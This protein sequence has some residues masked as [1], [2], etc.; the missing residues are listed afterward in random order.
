[1]KR[2][3]LLASVCGLLVAAAASSADAQ[4]AASGAAAEQQQSTTVGEVIVTAQRRAERLQDVPITIT[5]VSAQQLKDAN[6]QNLAQVQKL[7]PALRFDYQGPFYQPSIRG[8]GS[9]IVTSGAGSNVGIYVDGFFVPNPQAA[10]LQLLNVE[11]VQVLKGPQ[12]TLFGRNTTGGAIL[13]TTTRPSVKTSGMVD[14][15]YGNYNAQRYQGY[16][17]TGLG[18]RA[19][20]DL[21]YILS[22]GDGWVRNIATGDDKAGAYRNWSLRTGLNLDVTD[23]LSVLFH[24]SHY[25]T[26]DPT[27]ENHGVYVY[28]GQPLSPAAVV[29]GAI[30]ATRPGEVADT[31]R[32]GYL[33]KGDAYQLTTRLNLDFA[34]L[35]SYTQYRNEGGTFFQNAVPSSLN[36]VYFNVPIHDQTFSQ[37]F[38]LNS[39]PGRRLQWTAGAF[40]IDYRDLFAADTSFS[41]AP[42]SR[43]AGSYSDTVSAAIYAD[44][45]YQLLDKLYLTAGAR[46]SHDEVR[47]G[48]YQIAQLPRVYAPVLKGDRVTPRVVLR[49]TPDASSSVYASFSKGY[50][51]GIYNLGGDSLDAVEPERI[52]AYEVGYKR[53]ESRYSANVSAYY[54]D[55]TNLQVSSYG[56]SPANVPVGMVTNA[57][58]SRVFGLEGDGRWAVT[59]SLEL[60][61]SAAYTNAKYKRF[62]NAP[63]FT[64]CFSFPACGAA[65]GTLLPAI[66]DAGGLS[67][68]RAPEFTATA[69]ARYG[70]DLAGGRLVFSGTFYH[71]SKFYFNATDQLEQGAYNT[72]ALRAEWTDPSDRFTV[73]LYGDNVTGTRYLTEASAGVP[74]GGSVGWS[75]SALVAGEIRA[76]FP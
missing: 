24:Y 21:G 19:A 54:Y 31:G 27:V 60:N 47:H 70:M 22:E 30:Y 58:T 9:A 10:D 37:E 65:Y 48:Y 23:D 29:P 42:F 11:N 74:L 64:P 34:T 17:T 25:S 16:V 33:G 18:S 73:A 45:T 71:S 13:V 69:G 50:K 8:V 67:M 7:T 4:A 5:S 6:I 43:A 2:T 15:S 68:M 57:A 1:M 56:L 14:V 32:T 28:N 20:V 51:A 41:G 36:L 49:Y 55:Y 63:G 3:M 46:Y 53:A 12:G 26:N 39:K 72:L 59:D 76:R 52:T 61:A 44:L 38:L 75:A 62:P 35:T 66:V 40:Y